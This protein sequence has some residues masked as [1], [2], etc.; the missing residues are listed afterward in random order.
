MMECKSKDFKVAGTSMCILVSVT[1]VCRY[2]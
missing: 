2:S 1:I